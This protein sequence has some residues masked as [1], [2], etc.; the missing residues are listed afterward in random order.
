MQNKFRNYVYAFKK[1]FDT[2]I[3]FVIWINHIKFLIYS[4]YIYRVIYLKRDYQ[5][6]KNLPYNI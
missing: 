5:K 6:I 4:P 2:I 3:V 1:Y